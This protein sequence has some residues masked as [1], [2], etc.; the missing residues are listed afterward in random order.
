MFDGQMGH[1]AS[2]YSIPNLL[3]KYFRRASRFIKLQ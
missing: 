1:I 2:P 3:A